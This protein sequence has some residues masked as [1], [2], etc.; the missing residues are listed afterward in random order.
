MK[1]DHRYSNRNTIFFLYYNVFF[2]FFFLYDFVLK[3]YVLRIIVINKKRN[4]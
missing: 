2:F 4:D 1:C 3:L